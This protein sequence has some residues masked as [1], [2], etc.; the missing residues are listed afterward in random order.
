MKNVRSYMKGILSNVTIDGEVVRQYW[1]MV[2]LPLSD[3]KCLV[4]MMTELSVI[5]QGLR[6]AQDPPKS[7]VPSFYM[8]EN[9]FHTSH[10]CL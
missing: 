8:G 9:L 3:S 1:K 4:N 2:G 6:S 5:E 7:F 10:F